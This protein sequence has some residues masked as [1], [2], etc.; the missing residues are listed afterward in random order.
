MKAEARRRLMESPGSSVPLSALQHCLFCPRQCALIYI[1]RE[2][3]DNYLT[4][5]GS[6]EHERVDS[7]ENTTRPG[8]RVERSVH[9]YSNRHGL[10]GIADCVEYH[11]RKG[12][13]ERIVPVEYKHG[14]PKEHR[15][16]EV[17]L[18]AQA[19]CLEEMH[20]TPVRTGL[21]FYLRT[22]RRVEIAIDEELRALTLETAAHVRELIETG[23]M[24]PPSPG[25]H[26]RA[27]SL[28]DLCLPASVGGVL[29]AVAYNDHWA[30]HPE[31]LPP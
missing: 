28:V 22:R 5:K 4:A 15:A 14:Q 12:A 21:L 27:C 10:H 8:V 7:G 6:Q 11:G 18:C 13:W 26:C 2:W 17:Q 30:T 9:L 16:D 24:P 25:K 20:G 31:P 19:L 29:S 3:S 1:E 23:S